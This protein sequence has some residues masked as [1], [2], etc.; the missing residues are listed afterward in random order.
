MCGCAEAEKVHNDGR[1]KRL[2]SVAYAAGPYLGTAELA[3]IMLEMQKRV[4]PVV[5]V[6]RRK[7]VRDTDRLKALQ[8]KIDRLVAEGRLIRAQM[9]ELHNRDELRELR[10]L[11]RKQHARTPRLT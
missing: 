11:L 9:D 7:T 4:D 10:K 1:P 3:S 6:N 8:D 5:K 2:T